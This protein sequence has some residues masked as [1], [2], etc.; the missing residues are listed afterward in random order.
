VL[1]ESSEGADGLAFALFVGADA[2]EPV[3]V[4]VVWEALSSDVVGAGLVFAGG[5]VV[6]DVFAV[7][8]DGCEPV[9]A[10]FEAGA[11]TGTTAPD[12]GGVAPA[13]DG[14]AAGPGAGDG[15]LEGMGDAAESSPS[16]GSVAGGL[17]EGFSQANPWSFQWMY[18]NPT[19]SASATSTKTHFPAPP[20]LGGSSSSS[21]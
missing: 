15:V 21:R 5:A 11:G 9:P 3:G 14:F 2:L 18:P 17:L 7:C 13:V 1:S 8:V 19:A 12:D 10:G 4:S 16:E 20:P 6:G